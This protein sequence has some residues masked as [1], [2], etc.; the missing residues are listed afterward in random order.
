MG[1]S[2]SGSGEQAG[3]ESSDQVFHFVFLE[4][5]VLFTKDSFES[6]PITVKQVDG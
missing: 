2:E 3:D 1:S 6:S 5:G 4:V